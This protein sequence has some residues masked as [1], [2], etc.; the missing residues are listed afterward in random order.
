MCRFGQNHIYTPYMTIYLVVS[1]SKVPYINRIYIIMANPMYVCWRG[2]GCVLILCLSDLP[3]LCAVR[4]SMCMYVCACLYVCVLV[5][6]RM[7]AYTAY[8][9]CC[10]CVCV[11]CRPLR[12]FACGCMMHADM[13][14]YCS[15]TM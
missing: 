6:E 9:I 1:L 13:C 8:L 2:R 15:F 14:G 11:G 7:R 4:E 3:H 5:G 12:M 10:T